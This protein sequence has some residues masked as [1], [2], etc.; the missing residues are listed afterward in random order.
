MF[1]MS[2]KCPANDTMQLKSSLVHHGIIIA[3]RINKI[4]LRTLFIWPLF[5]WF[6]SI[7]VEQGGF[8]GKPEYYP[9]SDQYLSAIQQA[10]IPGPAYMS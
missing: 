1:A 2:H 7:D 6:F 9:S 8:Q 10:S 5:V 4:C 3:C